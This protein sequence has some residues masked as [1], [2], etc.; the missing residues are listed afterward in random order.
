MYFS[1]ISKNGAK[2]WKFASNSVPIVKS[3]MAK[4]CINSIKMSIAN[5]A[6]MISIWHCWTCQFQM[7]WATSIFLGHV[8]K[9][10]FTKGNLFKCEIQM[11]ASAHT[12]NWNFSIEYF[13]FF[14]YII[15][16]HHCYI[17]AFQPTKPFKKHMN[18]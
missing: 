15:L 2:H 9:H 12:H 7:I 1:W 18:Y 10:P 11:F 5:C 13:R 3:T 6:D 17:D 16:V 4:N 14:M 8:Q